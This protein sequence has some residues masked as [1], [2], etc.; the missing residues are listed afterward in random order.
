MSLRTIIAG[1]VLAG[2]IGCADTDELCCPTEFS[3]VQE[4]LREIEER[5]KR[6]TKKTSAPELCEIVKQM[7]QITEQTFVGRMWIKDNNKD[8]NSFYYFVS[9]L[10]MKV[11]LSAVYIP[12]PSF[13][14]IQGMQCYTKQWKEEKGNFEEW[15]CALYD[16]NTHLVP[17]IRYDILLK[18]GTS[19]AQFDASFWGRDN[20]FRE[21]AS[22]Y[23]PENRDK[24]GP[25]TAILA[26]HT[27]PMSADIF[28]GDCSEE[29]TAWS[30]QHVMQLAEFAKTM[31]NQ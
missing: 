2:G 29:M 13:K 3:T 16:G 1:M 25:V 17:S 4:Q 30:K 6:I 28:Q 27:G 11:Q 24:E 23:R 26:L 14:A 7:Q 9:D 19:L 20:Q 12:H 8:H 31:I 10:P 22:S 21:F 15:G 5:T 18:G